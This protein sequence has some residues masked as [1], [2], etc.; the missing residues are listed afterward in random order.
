[1]RTHWI[2]TAV[3]SGSVAVAVSLSAREPRPSNSDTYSHGTTTCLQGVDGP[4]IRLYLE[5]AHCEGK[6]SYPHL[7]LDIRE[8]PISAHKN[9]SIGANNGAFKC[10]TPKESCQQAL[11]GKI[12]F[13]PF[14]ENA[15]TEIPRT[16]GYYELRFNNGKSE[17][18]HFRVDRLAPCS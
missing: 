8:L 18:G 10:P 9:I 6:V 14:E 1:V 12:V 17:S 16:D 5:N 2:V 7:E 3:V 15:G 11:A 13:D 4:G